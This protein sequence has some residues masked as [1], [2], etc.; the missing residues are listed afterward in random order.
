M[1]KSS[2][3]IKDNTGLWHFLKEAW[4]I[5]VERAKIHKALRLL[6]KQSWSIE[7]LTALLYKAAKSYGTSLE[8]TITG[9]GGLALVVKTADTNT[10]QYKDENILEHLD[11]E[12]KV[13]QYI[14]SM[15]RKS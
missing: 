13:Q 4:S 12:V 8:M 14:T 15:Q 1:P 9:P 3:K 5:A 11:D 10:T 6:N 2:H 7:F